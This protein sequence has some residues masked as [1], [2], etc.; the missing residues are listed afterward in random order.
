M[1]ATLEK[2]LRMERKGFF[3]ASISAE[4]LGILQ[5]GTDPA[6]AAAGSSSSSSNMHA[7]EIQKVDSADIEIQEIP[8]VDT[9]AEVRS[10][11]IYIYIYIDI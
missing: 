10:V 6:V 7:P 4:K 8:V 11:D 2:C 3:K 9:F 5:T 1:V